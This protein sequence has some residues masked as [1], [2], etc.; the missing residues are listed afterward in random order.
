MSDDTLKPRQERF[1]KAVAQGVSA[2]D[3]IIQ[4]GYKPSSRNI[5]SAM[6]TNL[7]AQAKIKSALSKELAMVFPDCEK[8]A[9]NVIKECLFDPEAKYETKLKMLEFLAKVQGWFAPTKHAQLSVSVKDPFQLPEDK[10][11]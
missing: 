2:T 7:M 4:A 10:D 6:S 9:V 5:A 11:D 8:I 1:V 3:A